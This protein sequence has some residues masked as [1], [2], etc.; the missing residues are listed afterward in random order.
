MRIVDISSSCPHTSVKV[1]QWLLRNLSLDVTV[2][3]NLFHLLLCSVVGVH[4]CAMMLVV[5]KLHDL[6]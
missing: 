4:V 6:A 5:M 2:R 3:L 1:D